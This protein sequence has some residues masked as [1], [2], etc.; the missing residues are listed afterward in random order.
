MQ[1]R[2][3]VKLMQ[4]SINKHNQRGSGKS[5]C[6]IYLNKAQVW[7]ELDGSGKK[8]LVEPYVSGFESE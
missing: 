1:W 5:P 2:R 4:R 3:P 8:C 7:T 6:M